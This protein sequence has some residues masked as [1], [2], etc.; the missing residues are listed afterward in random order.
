MIWNHLVFLGG[1]GGDCSS[2]FM[3]GKYGFT[4]PYWKGEFYLQINIL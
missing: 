1:G 4:M 3:L 2:T